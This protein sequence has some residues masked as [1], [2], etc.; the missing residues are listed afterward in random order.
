MAV[1]E[2]S[3][4]LEAVL[5]NF[6]KEIGE[7]R[8]IAEKLM[9][10]KVI[11]RFNYTEPD[12]AI[13]IDCSQADHPEVFVNNPDI[14]PEIELWMNADTAHKFWL[15]KVNLVAAITKGQIKVKGSVP[16]LLMLLPAITPAYKIYPDYLKRSGFE[17]YLE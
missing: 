7:N 16:K 4:V 17:K 13:T 6:F 3:E 12:L 1:F 8:D 9:N 15:G 2:S 10:H 11:L 5:F 14:K